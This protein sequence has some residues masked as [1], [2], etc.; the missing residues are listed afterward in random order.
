[1]TEAKYELLSQALRG[2]SQDKEEG[3]VDRT[4]AGISPAWQLKTH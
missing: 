3:G 2:L 1:M 4:L